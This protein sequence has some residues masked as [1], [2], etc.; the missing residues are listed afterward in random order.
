V[1]MQIVLP[2]A[3]PRT[4]LRWMAFWRTVEQAMLRNP[5]LEDFASGE[6]APFLEGPV[7]LFLSEV[8]SEISAQAEVAEQERRETVAPELSGPL[9]FWEGAA[10]YVEVRGGWLDAQLERGP[11]AELTGLKPL[12]QECQAL[13][14]RV[15]ETVRE[16]AWAHRLRTDGTPDS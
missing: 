4:Y 15:V 9:E 8:V 1:I 14:M 12:D 13:R 3:P 5:A 16:H 7:A 6:S 10:D 11:V 2:P